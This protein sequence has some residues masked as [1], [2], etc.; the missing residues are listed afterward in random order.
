MTQLSIICSCRNDNYGENL[1][2]RLLYFLR[3]VDRFNIKTEVLIVEWN[4]LVN[5][6]K[7]SFIISKWNND[8]Q[9]KNKIRIITVSNEN[10]N[11]F[12]NKFNFSL[13]CKSF[14]EYPSKNVGIRNANGE[15]ILQTNPDIYYPKATIDNIEKIIQQKL[16]NVI[17][18]FPRGA[19]TDLLEVH[20]F[21]SLE[22]VKDKELLDYL[23][24]FER[25]DLK[26][27]KNIKNIVYNA[28]GDFLL[29]KKDDAIKSG[30]F[31]EYPLAIHHHEQP[32]VDAFKKF[33]INEISIDGLLIYHF[34]H[35]R[36]SYEKV[37]ETKK[38]NLPNITYQFLTNIN[39]DTNWGLKNINLNSY[40]IN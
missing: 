17:S 37:D 30:G 8:L 24:N 33:N 21:K 35:N 5:Y 31:K 23:D 26:N 16:N 39:N 13:P 6:E 9:F 4:P 14:Q 27:K 15:Y 38:I 28:L 11:N 29:F 18:T 2:D 34:D 20:N 36:I 32:F 3:S 25:I 7:L 40:N 19:R 10:H 12:I 1:L 22:N